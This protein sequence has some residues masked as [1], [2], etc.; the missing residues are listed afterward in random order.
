MASSRRADV[1]FYVVDALE[2]VT[3]QDKKLI[4]YLDREKVSFIM[5]VNKVDL[6]PRRERPQLERDFRQA[7]RICPHVPV[8]FVSALTGIR[9][10]ELL[11][12]ARE[13]W[14]ECGL[15]V[16][17][18]QLNRIMQEALS[19]HQPPVVKRRRAKFYYL[20][21]AGTRPPTFVF[22]VN[23]PE[24]IMPSYA[25]FLENQLRRLLGLRYAPL[26]VRFRV[27]GKRWGSGE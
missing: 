15:R 3:S 22:F 10:R 17:T 8:V 7:L 27:S 23:D 5:L 25:R 24:R 14:R 4:A 13:L 26:E 2:G 12:L 9:L 11:P 19:R 6:V 16:S 20:T 1:T 21:Q 18:G